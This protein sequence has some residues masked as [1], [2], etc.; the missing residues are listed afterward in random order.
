MAV[1]YHCGSDRIVVLRAVTVKDGLQTSAESVYEYEFI[2]QI[3]APKSAKKA[4]QRQTAKEY[5]EGAAEY[6]GF[7][8]EMSYNTQPQILASADELYTLT[9]GEGVTIDAEGNAVAEAAGLYTITAKIAEGCEWIISDPESG[10]L[11]YTTADQTFTVAIAKASIEFAEIDLADVDLVADGG[12]VRPKVAAVKL[13]DKILDPDTDYTVIYHGNTAGG[14]GIVV[15]TGRGSFA[16]EAEK[17]FRI[18]GPADQPG[19]AGKSRT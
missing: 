13:G 1:C 3:R 9:G 17:E 14:T 7:I 19:P 12:P 4:P 6:D 8:A 10:E 16:G 5:P 18:H 15:I 11:A 2:N